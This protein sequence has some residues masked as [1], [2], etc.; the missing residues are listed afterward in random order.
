M[1]YYYNDGNS[2]SLTL[3]FEYEE[4]FLWRISIFMNFNEWNFETY[5]NK[6]YTKPLE[7]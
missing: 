4:P 5:N 6:V 1:E 2:Y 7:K 3:H